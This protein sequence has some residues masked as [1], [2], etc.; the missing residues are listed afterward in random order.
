MF[1]LDLLR[2]LCLSVCT[3]LI[4]FN[5]AFA[6]KSLDGLFQET[7]ISR[8]FVGIVILIL[9][10]NDVTVLVPASRNN[11]DQVLALTIGK[12]VQ[13]F[14][15][16]IPFV[17]LLAWIMGRDMNLNF[18]QFEVVALFG[19]VLYINSTLSQGRSSYLDGVMLLSVFL[20]ICLVSFWVP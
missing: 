11:M 2:T 5:T 8:T 12:C 7:G 17:V 14:L 16:V 18:D 4:T 10:N 15:L 19:S 13:T 6:T 20:I 1:V 9:L 3:T